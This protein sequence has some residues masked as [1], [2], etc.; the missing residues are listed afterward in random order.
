[1]KYY[2]KENIHSNVIN[3]EYTGLYVERSCRLQMEDDS[4]ELKN[5]TNGKRRAEERR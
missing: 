5:R 2:I 1:M 3:L 4:L